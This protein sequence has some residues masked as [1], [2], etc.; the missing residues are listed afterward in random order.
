MEPGLKKKSNR[1]KIIEAALEVFAEKGFQETKISEISKT[2][3]VSDATIYEYFEGKEDLLFAISETVTQLAIDLTKAVLPYLRDPVSKVRAHVQITITA[4]E[5]N[6]QYAAVGMLELKTNRRFHMSESY[7]TVQQ[8][9]HFWLDSIREGIEAGVF[10]KDI[11]PHLMRSML[12]GAIEHLCTRKHLLGVPMD[13]AQ[14]VDPIMD[15]ILE[16]ARVKPPERAF[17][18]NLQI[19]D[20]K[21]ACGEPTGTS[22]GT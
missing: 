2:A 20:G 19:G 4:Y 6:P 1:E 3:G 15:L 22:G 7:K 17:S 5:Q 12:L 10:R 16:G 9:A 18:I 13:L 8:G 14:Y 21:I 11:D